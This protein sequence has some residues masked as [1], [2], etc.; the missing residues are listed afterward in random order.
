[1]KKIAIFQLTPTKGKLTEAVQEVLTGDYTKGATVTLSQADNAIMA[2]MEGVDIGRIDSAMALEPLYNTM[3][4][5]ARTAPE[6]GITE[7]ARHPMATMAELKEKVAQQPLDAKLFFRV[8][9]RD[10][11]AVV[12]I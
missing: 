2:S 1:M 8:H 9:L 5:W 4:L 10:C 12:D 3:Q 6:L 7:L 11:F